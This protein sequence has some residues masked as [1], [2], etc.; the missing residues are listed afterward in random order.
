MKKTLQFIAVLALGASLQ[1][2]AQTQ[3]INLF[4]EWTGENC[5]PCAATNP[6]ITAIA[7]ANYLGPK[8]LILLRYQVAIPSAP[9][10]PNS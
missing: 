1:T 4:E 6:G 8:K 7:N 3:R 5:A 2:Q 10:N 9:T